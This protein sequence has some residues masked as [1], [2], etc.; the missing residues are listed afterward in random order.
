MIFGD[1]QPDAQHIFHSYLTNQ[2]IVFISQKL[3][4]IHSNL[5][6]QPL[7][8]DSKSNI[9]PADQVNLAV[10]TYIRSAY[11][12]NG[13]RKFAVV[14]STLNDEDSLLKKLQLY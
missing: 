4:N 6:N 10:H 7:A 3:I 12:T 11:C 5:Q 1:F 14:H 2:S 8:A 13:V 9:S